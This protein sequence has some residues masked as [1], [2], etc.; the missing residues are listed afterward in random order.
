MDMISSD[1]IDHKVEAPEKRSY[2]EHFEME[3]KHLVK[4][5]EQMMRDCSNG[6]ITETEFSAKHRDVKQMIINSFKLDPFNSTFDTD[7]IGPYITKLESMFDKSYEEF[8]K[9]FQVSN[10]E[11]SYELTDERPQKP[12]ELTDIPKVIIDF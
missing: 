6:A 12:S 2:D 4:L 7:L 5:Y 8:L 1:P 10:D 11:K 9:P 3:S